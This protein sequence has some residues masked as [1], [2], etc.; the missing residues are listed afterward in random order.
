MK[1]VR[2]NFFGDFVAKD[3]I[4]NNISNELH[5]IIS[6]A[7]V[8]V[9][10]FE[11][12]V[13]SDGKNS[14]KSGPSLSQDKQGIEW[15]ER[16]GFNVITLANNHMM[17]HGEKGLNETILSVHKAVVLGAG[18][19]DKVYKPLI[20]EINGIII[21][22]LA[23]THCEFGTLTDKYDCRDCAQFGTAWINHP[24]VDSIIIETKKVVDYLIVLP[25]AGLE[26]VEQP[27]PEWRDRYKSLIDLGAD[28]VIASH[29]HIIQGFEEYKSRPIFYSLG[30]FYFPWKIMTAETWQRSICV[31]LNLTKD[32]L[33]F[34]YHFLKFSGSSIELDTSIDAPEYMSRVMNTL[35]D[36]NKYTAFINEICLKSLSTYGFVFYRSGMAPWFSY[37][38]IFNLK[39]IAGRFLKGDII[40]AVNTIRC[41]THRYALLRGWKLKYMIQ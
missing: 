8:N 25:H 9:V 2:V 27:L 10:N 15:L 40:H 7:S 30:N 36:N 18:T 12:P 39:K 22:F 5:N 41:E 14:Y 13:H 23:L 31:T 37:R 26:G 4:P 32:E 28:A 21:G 6:R 1:Q 19:W 20:V 38:N 35:Y 24:C 11:A 34:E 3:Y 33:F 17:D 16:Q 29:P